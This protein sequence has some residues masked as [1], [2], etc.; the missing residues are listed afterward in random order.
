[1][2]VFASAGQ[3]SIVGSLEYN[4]HSFVFISNDGPIDTGAQLTLR[5]I[6]VEVDRSNGKLQY[7]AGYSPHQSWRRETIGSPTI[8][9]VGLGVVDYSAL[10]PFGQSLAP[11]ALVRPT[12]DQKSGWVRIGVAGAE[13]SDAVGYEIAT[14]TIVMIDEAAH[15]ESLW[16]KPTFRV[17][18]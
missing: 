6:E 8:G 7:A 2:I 12:F 17:G 9:G 1:M 3:G 4:D 5:T 10:K 14:N 18:I 15:F 11:D 16:L 13:R